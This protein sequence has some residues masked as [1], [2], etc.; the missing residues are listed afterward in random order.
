MKN[1][2]LITASVFAL[3]LGCAITANAGCDGIY[4]AGRVGSVKHKTDAPLSGSVSIDKDVL[5]LSGAL[6]YR[7]GYVRT[8][9][10]Y[11]WRDK[12]DHKLGTAVGGTD[13]W[14]SE[15]YMWNAYW[16]LSPYTWF[17]PYF[18]A[19]IGFTKMEFISDTGI[20]KFSE[21]HTKFTWSLGGGLSAQITNRLNLDAGYRY[22][23]FGNFKEAKKVNAQ[24]IYGGV[25]Y[26]F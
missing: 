4:L 15:S 21:K 6:G 9:L 24:E 14:N 22:Y 19:G 20:L 25:R 16:D 17:T 5:M 1:K 7:Y 18:S 26:V 12:V 10:E 3:S 11:V 23:N 13:E 8:E 2:M